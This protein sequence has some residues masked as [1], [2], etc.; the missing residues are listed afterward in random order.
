MATETKAE[1]PHIAALKFR[2]ETLK[3]KATRFATAVSTPDH[4]MNA[5]RLR[6]AKAIA[7]IEAELSKTK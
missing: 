5:L 6:T 3:D 2:L 1:S 4:D 7:E